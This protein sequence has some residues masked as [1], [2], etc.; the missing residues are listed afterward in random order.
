[1]L[2][3]TPVSGKCWQITTVCGR[4]C[5]SWTKLKLKDRGACSLISQYCIFMC[6]PCT[7]TCACACTFKCVDPVLI[8]VLVLVNVWTLHL[9]LYLEKCHTDNCE[10]CAQ[11]SGTCHTHN[12]E[13][14]VI[15]HKTANMFWLTIAEK[16]QT[17]TY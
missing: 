12:I 4:S 3:M 16:S 15:Q 7:C 2:K 17:T 10:Y 14:S 9:F 11:N 13:P 5:A 6:G 8:L 1:M